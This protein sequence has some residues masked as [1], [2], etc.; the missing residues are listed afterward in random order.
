[1]SVITWWD[2]GG[3]L[4]SPLSVLSDVQDPFKLRLKIRGEVE[5]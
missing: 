2:L 5:A 3:D 1:M 4:G